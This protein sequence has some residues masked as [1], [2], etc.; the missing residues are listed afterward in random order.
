MAP[1]WPLVDVENSFLL[2]N[3][4]EGGVPRDAEL[5]FGG[6]FQRPWL[7]SHVAI[8]G[9]DWNRNPTADEG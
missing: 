4:N 2:Y 1:K 7:A 3:E 6:R 9:R 5:W 8:P